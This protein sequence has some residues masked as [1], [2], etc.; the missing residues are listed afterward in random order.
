MIGLGSVALT[1]LYFHR[2]EGQF[3]FPRCTFYQTTGL[4]CPGCGGLRATH[5]L[6]HGDIVEAARCNLLL[7]L[8]LPSALGGWVWAR[9]RRKSAPLNARWIWLLFGVAAIFT[10]ARNL[11][12]PTAGW[13]SP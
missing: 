11:P 5:A 9:R 13:L 7:V 4:L 1:L 10:I 3:F 6:L 2:P 8:G 12:G